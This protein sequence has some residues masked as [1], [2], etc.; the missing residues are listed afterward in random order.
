MLHWL[1]VS[2]L[3]FTQAISI[4][5]VYTCFLPGSPAGPGAGGA[6]GQ[7]QVRDSPLLLLQVCHIHAKG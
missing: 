2:P 5:N 4:T 3:P 6:G 7:I 1:S